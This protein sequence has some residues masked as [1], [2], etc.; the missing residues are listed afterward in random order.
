MSKKIAP[1]KSMEQKSTIFEQVLSN[2][3]AH[4]KYVDETAHEELFLRNKLLTTAERAE[5]KISEAKMVQADGTEVIE[6]RLYKLIDATVVKISAEV[7]VS[8]EKG[9]K[10]VRE[11]N[12][13]G[14]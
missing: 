7:T 12:L 8:T 13:S 11:G 14:K 1:M 9:L 10:A 3:Q 2:I 4:R 6:L 5:Y